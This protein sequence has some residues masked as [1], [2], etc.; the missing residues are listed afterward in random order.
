[1]LQGRPVAKLV[2]WLF[3]TIAI[4]IVFAMHT[5]WIF[6]HFAIDGYLYD[7]GWIAYLFGSADPLI[8]NPSSISTLSFYAHHLSPHIFLFGAPLVWVFQLSGITILAIHQGLFFSLFLLASWLVAASAPVGYPTRAIVLASGLLIGAFSNALF[9]A[10]AY[11]HYEIAMLTITTLALA[12]GVR[13]HWRLF[14]ACLVWLPLVREDGGFFA[15]FVCGMC[16][17]LEGWTGGP[18][19]RVRTLAIVTIAEVIVALAAFVIKAKFFPGFAAFAGNFS[20]HDWGHV[21]RAFVAERLYSV[22]T[23]PSIVPVL[24][25]SV[26]LAIRDWRYGAGL[27]L[28]SPLYGIHVL[29]VREEHGHFTLYYALPWLL[30]PLTWLAVFAARGRAARAHVA[31]AVVIAIASLALAAPVHAALGFRWQFWYVAE[32]SF[33]RP[34]ANLASMEQFVPWAIVRYGQEPGVEPP[35]TNAGAQA[36][37][38]QGIAALMP[39]RFTP[40]QVVA[41]GSDLTRCRPLMLLNADMDYVALTDQAR[42]LGFALAGSRQNAEMWLPWDRGHAPAPTR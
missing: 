21:T 17:V 30:P 38:S 40:K 1:M 27:L 10:A 5:R 24:V 11:P 25:A 42:R 41:G 26:I 32:W 34:V 22:A 12:A 19:R 36:C 2:E 31:E 9:Q 18:S 39:D 13:G 23:N 20:G 37:V 28:L 7:S 8:H 3:L 33:S 4:V 6:T 14:A 29:S 15:A 35:D 16:I